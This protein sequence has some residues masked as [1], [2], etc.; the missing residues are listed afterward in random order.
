MKGPGEDVHERAR[1]LERGDIQYPPAHICLLI[2][3]TVLS[4]IHPILV[5]IQDVNHLVWVLQGQTLT[6]V[7][8]KDLMDPVT[9]TLISC[10]YTETLEKGRGNPVYLGLKEPELCLFCTKVK[11][12]DV[13]PWDLLLTEPVKPFLFYHDQN[14]RASSFE[15]VAFPGWFIG[16]CSNGGCPVIITQELGK[17]YTTDFGFTV[18]QA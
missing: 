5:D 6:A 4:R 15:S 8:R 11:G 9:V 12:H 3:S 13:S 2:F 17:I 10:K 1:K 7:P 18:L 16:S 14:G